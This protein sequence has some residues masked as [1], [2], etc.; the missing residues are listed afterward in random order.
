MYPLP[1]SQSS[2][3]LGS[4]LPSGARSTR[5]PLGYRS[6]YLAG[7]GFRVQGL[8][9]RVQA[10]GVQ[11]KVPS[12]FRVEGLGF[13]VQGLGF[14]VQGLGFGP[15]GYR[16]KHLVHTFIQALHES[17]SEL[18]QTIVVPTT[19]K[20][21]TINSQK[22]V[23]WYIYYVKRLKKMLFRCWGTLQVSITGLPDFRVKGLGFRV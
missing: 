12:V 4:G 5:K 8:G 9:F 7:V 20:K 23:P 13:R 15:L 11:V 22:S 21:K 6:K 3:F 19:K 2:S 1:A 16:S 18:L 17:L 14:K 10:I